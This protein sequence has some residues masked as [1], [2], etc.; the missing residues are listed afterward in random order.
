MRTF[1]FD[2]R[3]R[4][5]RTELVLLLIASLACVIT[6][7]AGLVDPS[8]SGVA[9][10]TLQHILLFALVGGATAIALML[11][12]Q[13][14][15]GAAQAI[16]AAREE[17]AELRR[18]LVAAEAI[19]KAEPQTI[20]CWEHGRGL[21]VVTHTLTTVPGLPQHQPDLLRFGQW[22]EP[23]SATEL[24]E[25][26][27][28][29][30][31]DGRPFTLLIR[32]TAGGHLE[33]DGRTAGGSAVLRF[34]D[35]SV[36]KREIIQ[37]ANQ[38]N[39]LGRE[40]R[41]MRAL[42]DAL[43]MPVW[44]RGQNGRLEWVNRAYVQAVEARDANEVL[45]RQSELLEQR[46][47]QSVDRDIEKKKGVAKRVNLITGGQRKAHDLIVVPVD[48]TTA[49]AAID[50]AEIESARGELDRQIAAYDRTLDRVATAVAIFSRDQRLTFFNDA[51]VKLWQLDTEWL[52][53]EPTDGEV[54]DRLRERGRL[55]EVINYREWKTK[56][57]ERHK[58]GA[59]HDDWWHLPDGRVL[60][61]MAEQR[62]DGGVTYLYADETER[63]ALE[64]R[65]NALIDVQRE[66]L[67]AL[68][69]GVAVFGTDGR[70]K[71]FNSSFAA[72]WRQSR[73][74]LAEHPHI[75]EIIAQAR[76]L[77]DDSRTWSRIS[78]AVTSFSDHRE[79]LEGQMLRPDGSV[80]DFAAT[81]LPDG[82][83]LLTFVDVSA[84]KRY[85]RA[86]LERNEALIAGDRLKNQFISHVS[87]ELRTPLTNIIGFSELLSSPRAGELNPKQREYL[88]DIR[89]SSKTLLAII[90]DI[91]DL[92]TIDAGSLE[93]KLTTVNVRAVIDAAVM[94]VRERAMRARLT[95]DIAIADDA[96]EFVAD[97]S[98]VRQVLYNLLSNAIG[99]SK[100]EGTVR[101]S[102]WRETDIMV[103][104]IEDE[105]VGI[106]KEQLNRVF[107]RFESR[108]RGS[109]HR[110]AGLGLSIVKSLVE[111][112]GGN[113]AMDSE[114]GRGTR[115]TVRLPKGGLR[116]LNAPVAAAEA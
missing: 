82:A 59:E 21:R 3:A 107:D 14:T 23:K 19:I 52:E 42:M 41:S 71:L 18:S 64:S 77:Y 90:D 5:T 102:C 54:L 37:L 61:V 100:T 92:T 104:T 32:S 68:K 50:V 106:P 29:L 1:T 9:A 57:L 22:L 30:F 83:T 39:S 86:L 63:L 110:G 13:M 33:A 78:H 66:T 69:E 93:L 56:L 98:R 91:L 70:L 36:A 34:R 72:V 7:T 115:V 46:Q 114:P 103:F 99:F 75:D 17:S 81:P 55:P 88:G 44:L 47:R 108:S 58:S 24:K 27:D 31:E 38:Q 76:V 97:E 8:G 79:P 62:P 116:Q 4:N 89:S 101:V 109:K 74:T 112:H 43:P 45:A 48:D 96:D 67:D 73:R 80:I 95:L 16:E 111:L 26:L 40:I 11:V 113:M 20:I 65:Y 53:A 49:A 105:G 12:W 60:H 28:R 6:L 85:E 35:V 10:V 84:S 87:Y 2:V 15:R 94:G 25:G 51:F